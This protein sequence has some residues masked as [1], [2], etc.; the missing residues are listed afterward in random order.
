MFKNPLFSSFIP[1]FFPPLEQIPALSFQSHPSLQV[2][3]TAVHHHLLSS[4]IQNLDFFYPPLIHPK[5]TSF[6]FP[7]F[8]PESPCSVHLVYP[9]YSAPSLP[10]VS[11]S[12]CSTLFCPSLSCP[13]CLLL[14]LYV[15]CVSSYKSLNSVYQKK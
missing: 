14:P 13:S 15:L 12:L 8:L 1:L 3:K 4:P 5:P 7:A 9:V 6:K 10:Q 2:F 11:S